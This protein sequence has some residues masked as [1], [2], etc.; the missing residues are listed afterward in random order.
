VVTIA[1][2]APGGFVLAQTGEF[3]ISL[4]RGVGYSLGSQLQGTFELRAGG[5]AE[6]DSVAYLIDGVKLGESSE[7]PF[8]VRFNTEDYAL[9]VHELQAETITAD[10]RA[11]RSNALRVEFVPQR[12]AWT[13]MR[14][15]IVPGGLVLAAA[16]A[17]MLV[18]SLVGARRRRS[19][20]RFGGVE[21]AERA[22]AGAPQA[23]ARPPA[24]EDELRRRIDDSR[25]TTL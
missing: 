13:A 9:G 3:T 5:I 16:A 22:T 19:R 1:L 24:P 25:Y 15:V 18:F 4:H 17:A 12:A 14:R 10:G 21:A 20:G 7:P 11:I 2:V 8:A 6:L 23:V